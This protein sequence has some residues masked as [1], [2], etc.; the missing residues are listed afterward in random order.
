MQHAAFKFGLCLV[1]LQLSAFASAHTHTTSTNPKSGSVLEHSP[2]TI[3]I[4]FKDPVRMTAVIVVQ[5]GKPDRKL[6]S[7]P[8]ETATTFTIA[9]PNLAAGRNEVRW[10]ALSKDGHVMNGVIELTIKSAH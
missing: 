10:T 1:L 6:E 7:S 4:K 3:E 8:R 9:Q 2:P 5:D